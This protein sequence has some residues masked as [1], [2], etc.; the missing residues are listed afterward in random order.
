M[1]AS[2]TRANCFQLLLRG[3]IIFRLLY[4]ERRLSLY[5]NCCIKGFTFENLSTHGV[6]HVAHVVQ[7]ADLT[8]ETLH[9]GL[10]APNTDHQHRG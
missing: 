3:V 4:F 6:E 9:L 8:E 10:C 7:A 2:R 1:F 5:F